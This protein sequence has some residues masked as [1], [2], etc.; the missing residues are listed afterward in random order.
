MGMVLGMMSYI[1]LGTWERKATTIMV[2]L[3]F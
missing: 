3:L 2:D 1:M